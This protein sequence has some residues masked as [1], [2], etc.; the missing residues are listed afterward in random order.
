MAFQTLDVIDKLKEFSI[1]SLKVDGGGSSSN[2]LCQFLSD[3]SGLVIQRPFELECTALG[4]AYV[5][6]LSVGLWA[7]TSQIADN[8]K[9][10]R[11]FEPVMSDIDRER[12]R[13]QWGQ[14]VQRTLSGNG[15]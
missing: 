4:T 11:I 8:W 10:E 1:S 9:A 7:S 3:I 13:S 15:K 14:A 5:A 6:G 12:Y 2:F